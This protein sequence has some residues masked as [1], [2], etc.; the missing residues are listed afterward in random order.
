MFY[1][2]PAEPTIAVGLHKCKFLIKFRPRLSSNIIVCRAFIDKA[3]LELSSCNIMSV[4]N[5]LQLSNS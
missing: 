3:E 1:C 4:I 5:S 2:L